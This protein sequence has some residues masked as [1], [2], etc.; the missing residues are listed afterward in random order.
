M[1]QQQSFHKRVALYPPNGGDPV[2]PH[3]S[4]VDQMIANGWRDK[5]PKQKTETKEEVSNG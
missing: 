2:Y 5:A 1:T 4:K 3:P